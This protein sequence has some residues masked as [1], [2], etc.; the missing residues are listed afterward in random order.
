MSFDAE[1]TSPY[2]A[3]NAA[4]VEE[5]Y[6]RYLADPHSVDATWQDYFKSRAHHGRKLRQK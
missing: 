3:G 5:L 1:Q 2:F 6:T 4:F